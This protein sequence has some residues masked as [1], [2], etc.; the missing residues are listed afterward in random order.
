MSK[1]VL[2]IGSL[3]LDIT[4]S[5]IGN[6]NTWAEK[7]RIS[8]ITMQTGGDA[9]NQAL[10]LAGLG[11]RPYLVSVVG[12]DENGAFL[13][14]ALKKRGVVTDHTAV[15]DDVS[16][17]TALVLVD[18]DGQRSTFSVRGAHSTLCNADLSW[19]TDDIL[20]EFAA[21][22]LASPFSMPLLEQDGL[23]DLLIRAKKMRIPVFSDL[24]S[25]KRGQGLDGI[26]AFLPYFDYFLPSLYDAAAMTAPASEDSIRLSSDAPVSEQAAT[27]AAVYHTFGT[28]NVLIKC[29]AQGCYVSSP[30]FTGMVS[31]AAVQVVDTTGA[32]DCMVAA[33][34][35]RI[36]AGDDVENACRF[37]CAAGSWCTQ[38]PGASAQVI[39]Q[40]AVRGLM[41]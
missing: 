41:R 3:V 20:S 26:R 17:G 29:G 35:S 28:A 23:L 16:T 19:L 13:R 25:D 8:S 18:E 14:A 6:K 4:A 27:A 22:S 21:I 34:I 37:A 15:R 33:F 12:S 7:Q 31:A 32:G 9:A 2:V 11:L 39:S 1:K 36:L 30:A 5:P 24:A 40:E 10:H 38:Y